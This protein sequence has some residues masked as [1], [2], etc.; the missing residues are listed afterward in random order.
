MPI[1]EYECRKCGHQFEFL[2]IPSSPVASCPSCHKKD[3]KQLISL[4]AVSSE[5]T[6]Q[7][8]FKSARKKAVAAQKGQQYEEHKAAHHDD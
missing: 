4:C 8:H 2:V 3:L 5:T 6:R 7:A 1:Y